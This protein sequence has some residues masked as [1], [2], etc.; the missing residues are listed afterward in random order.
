MSMSR[1]FF[2]GVPTKM[3]VARLRE[4]YPDSAMKPGDK[5]AYDDVGKIIGATYGTT[6]FTGVTNQ[7]RRVVERESNVIIGT[8]PGEAFVVLN[9]SEKL[10]LSGLKLRTA[11]RAARRAWVVGSRIDRKELSEDELRRLDHNSEVTSRILSSAQV[12]RPQIT[13]EI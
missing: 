6:R 5:M 13:P 1:P 4:K 9:E 3:D 7:W 2:G 8:I 12:K 11:G 10:D